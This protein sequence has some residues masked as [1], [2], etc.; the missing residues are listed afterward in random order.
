M[1]AIFV[2]GFAILAILSGTFSYVLNIFE[3]FV[4]SGL[5]FL[6][7][8]FILGKRNVLIWSILATIL[9]ITVTSY[10]LY[11]KELLESTGIQIANFVKPYYYSMRIQGFYIGRFHQQLLI[12]VI[13]IFLYRVIVAFYRSKKFVAIPPVVGALLILGAYIAGAFSSIR[14]RQA[15][16][17]FVIATFIY[18]F[19]IYY[20]RL[21]DSEGDCRRYS[22]Y[23]LSIVMATLVILLSL[24]VNNTHPNPFEKSVAKV[25]TTGTN[26]ES[27]PNEF[28][29]DQLEMIY[30]VAD[31]YKIASSFEHQGIELFRVKTEKLKYFKSQTFNQY[32]DGVWTNTKNEPIHQD[33]WPTEPI[34]SS[35]QVFNEALFFNE[36]VEVIYQNIYTDSIVTGPYTK[37]V[38]LSDLTIP[39]HVYEDGMF[40]ADEMVG[41]DYQYTLSILIPK[42]RTTALTQYLSG[43]EKDDTDLTS[44][45]LLPDGF[46]KL[47]DLSDEI[48]KDLSSDMNKAIAIE[49]YLKSAYTYNENPDFQHEGDMINAF[50]FEEKEGFCQQFA[51]SMTLMLRSQGIPSRFVTGFVIGSGQF[52]IDDI[53][54]EVLYNGRRVIDSYK[55]VYDSNAHAW[56]EIYVPNFGWIQF[57]PTPGQDAVQFSDPIQLNDNIQIQEPSTMDTIIHNDYFGIAIVFIVFAGLVL[58]FSAFIKR[59]KRLRRNV[60]RRLMVDYKLLWIYL[61][62]IQLEKEKYETLREYALR[63]NKGL[64][65]SKTKFEA[66]I[67]TLE[68]A[69]YNDEDPSIEEVE[70]LEDYLADIKHIVKRQMLPIHFYRLRFI[71]MILL[72]K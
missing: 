46:D 3:L 71:E 68:K 59:G 33:E 16:F 5:S 29:L 20:V 21:K 12:L 13:G 42:Y 11:K 26:G 31:A 1:F 32:V 41:Q 69:F 61:K 53:P 72:H 39:I 65:N 10:Y 6:V 8:Y 25:S 27:S 60:K 47:K 56:V 24:V 23:R 54:E 57:E 49:R 40:K 70:A 30:S 50:L 34:L 55:H 2:I 62:A 9:A 52:E 63:L 35:D 36:E 48:T 28:D 64:I 7:Y 19:E 15:F 18:Y 37:E 66:Y 44:Y 17:L 4:I 58:L 67:N 14:D 43:L 51:T 45:L 22:F 38:V